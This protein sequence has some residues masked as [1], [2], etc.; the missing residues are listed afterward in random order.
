[1]TIEQQNLDEHVGEYLSG[2]IDGELTQQ[3][4]QWVELHCERCADC[5]R[6]KQELSALR[7]SVSGAKL[8]PI[9]DDRW[10]ETMNDSGVQLTGMIGWVLLIAGGLGLGGIALWGIISDSGLGAF[11]KFAILAFYGGFAVLLVSVLRQR[12]I[13]RKTD[14]YKDVEI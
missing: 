9:G 7:A 5:N 4:R 6:L 12:L 1:M 8:S 3:Q 13:E 11:M 10:R 14:K 2:Y